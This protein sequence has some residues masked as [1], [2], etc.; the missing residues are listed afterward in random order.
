MSIVAALKSFQSGALEAALEQLLRAW[1]QSRSPALA[2][3]ITFVGGR[4]DSTRKRLPSNRAA[5]VAAWKE[6][7]AR[8]DA[9]D[10]GVLLAALD[11]L[12]A[13]QAM[14]LTERLRTFPADPRIVD[15]LLALAE[16][17]PT[18]M[19]GR[20][21]TPFWS[22]AFA[23]IGAMGDPRSVARLKTLRLKWSNDS[24]ARRGIHWADSSAVLLAAL[25][26]VKLAPPP[27]PKKLSSRD[28]KLLEG[29]KAPP[30]SGDVQ[31]LTA[32]VFEQPDDD[33]VRRVLGDLLLERGDVRGELINLQ[34]Q[35]APDAAQRKRMKELLDRHA[36]TWLGPLEPAILKSGLVYRRG[37]PAAAKLST[38]QRSVVEAVMGRPEWNTFEALDLESWPRGSRKAF[39]AQPLLGLRRASMLEELGELP[40]RPLEWQALSLR[41]GRAEH[42]ELLSKLTTLPKLRWFGFESQLRADEHSTLA[43]FWKSPVARRLEAIS[44]FDFVEWAL[45][46]PRN[47]VR[48]DDRY[49]AGE[50]TPNGLVATI[51]WD[52]PQSL[53]SF[54]STLAAVKKQLHRVTVTTKGEVERSEKKALEKAAGC[55]VEWVVRGAR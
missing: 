13:Q 39:L 43:G 42:L 5:R 51:N 29:L 41:L 50:R 26:G 6:R 47:I 22:A 49:C 7:A 37:F 30:R 35:P 11:G 19:R 12:V 14:P 4:V 38:N 44:G 8:K 55:S 53:S 18:G 3:A 20:K 46:A 36:R 2:E 48:L 16:S 10:V 34:L 27:R 21:A 31:A 52:F 15:A 28:T 25:D 23:T 24:Q 1:R 40:D 33:D 32:K 17:P 54:R 45:E 9:A